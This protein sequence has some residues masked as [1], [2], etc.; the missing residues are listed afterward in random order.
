MKR[1][2][3]STLILPITL[4]TSTA[5]FSAPAM[6]QIEEII[7]TARKREES[8]QSVPISVTAIDTDSLREKSI[9]N[10]YDLTLHVPGMTVRQGSATRTA[11]D[12]FIRGQGATF[13]SASGVVVYYG[14]VPLKGVGLAGSNL[15]LFDLE[16]VQVLKGPQGTLF[17]RSSTGGAV[18]FAPQK[19]TDEFGGYVDTK[20][21]NLGTQE[22]SAALNLPLWE[23]K[24]SVRGAIN[25]QRRDGFTESQSTGQDQDDRHRETYRLGINF[26]PV[27]WLE[28]YT[29]LQHNNVDEGP[30][31]A[32]LASVNDNFAL[33]NTTPLQG[34]GWFGIAAPPL[35]FPGLENGGL[36]WAINPGNLAGYQSCSTQRLGLIDQLKN[37]LDTE[38]AR[39]EGGGSI[40]K[41]LTA[42]DGAVKGRSQQ[43]INTT[44]IDIG[45]MSFLGDVSLKTIL[46]VNR[47][48]RSTSIREFGATQY[49]HGVVINGYDLVGFPQQIA[50]F[51]NQKTSFGDDFTQEYQILGDING[52][53]SWILGYFNEEVESAYNPPPVFLTFN[54]AFQVPIGNTT[55]L[56]PS[57]S[58][59]VNEQTG[60]FGQF[61][62]DL[63]DMLLDGL[64]FTAGYRRTESKNTQET[65]QLI[66]G[67]NGFTVGP[68]INPLKFSESAPS[69]TATLDYQINPDVLV[70]LAHRR[71]FKP[72]GINGTSAAAGIPG[73]RDTYDP[74]TLDDIEVGIKADWQL[75]SVS[76]RS[77]VAF[78]NSWYEDVQRSEVVPTP[79]GGVITQINN[80]AAAEITGV[81]MEHQFVFNEQVQM[82]INYTWTDAR[83]T[84]WPGFTET[85]DGVM[86]PNTKSPFIGTPEHQATIGVRYIVPMDQAY[87][88]LSLYGEY[89]R[90]SGVWLDDESLVSFPRR[91]GYQESYDNV[92]LR[93][94]WT[95]AIGS[96]F[97]ASLY[98]RNAMDDEWIVGSN[99]LIDALGFQTNTWNEPRTY[100]LQLR[101]RFGADEQK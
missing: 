15:Q 59:S 70:Y 50:P 89:Y 33:F 78:Y 17:G 82:F 62:V 48:T 40:R 91:T 61:T 23:D 72:G 29:L 93:I 24:L 7:V 32:V 39:V 71:G 53:H 2:L 88:S 73:S 4:T 79:S 13:G 98:V 100:G 67:P 6:S 99:S 69:W 75:G 18:L 19:P 8:L 1:Q 94:D 44:T 49:S 22:V 41:N 9:E 96:S 76:G 97:D 60:I 46:G 21:G 25:I 37:D 68:L 14:E 20:V 85:I 42:I 11:V 77:N 30:T 86:L 54:N 57:T 83:Y 38:L 52:K 92:N 10:P 56:F 63:S 36:C 26:K 51:G 74:E 87:G 27:E 65:Y 58:A 12:Y 45:K 34:A 101:Y 31:G 90:Q 80:T 43:I 16:S 5:F 81:E 47:I 3:L 66:P 35:P 28:N 55:F 95:N 84:K 64:K